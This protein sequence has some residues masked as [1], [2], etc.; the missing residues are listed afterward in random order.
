MVDEVEC[1]DVVGV[2]VDH[3]DVLVAQVLLD[4]SVPGV[5][6]VFVDLYGVADVLEVLF[7]AVFFDD[8]GQ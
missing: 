1:L 3:C 6:G 8:G 5:I 4:R 7:G 2:F